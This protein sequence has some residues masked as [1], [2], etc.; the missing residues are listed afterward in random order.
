MVGVLVGLGY[1][2]IYYL[3][4]ASVALTCRKLIK[5]PDEVFR[6]TLHFILLGS[7]V[8]W[9]IGFDSWEKSAIGCIIFEIIVFPILMLFERLKNYSKVVTERKKGELKSSLLIVFT[10]FAL[11]ICL[12]WGLL[13]DKYLV[14]AS[15]YT[16]GFGDAFA[17]LIG[18]KYGKHKI[19]KKKSLEGS[20]AMFIVSLACAFIILTIR[21]ITPWY[22]IIV[23]SLLVS[24]V[25]TIVEL[26][27]PNGLDTI[28][29]PLSAMIVMLSM[30]YIFG[31]LM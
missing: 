29:C 14:F 24:F 20:I 12:C 1:V 3:I 10:T 15:I 30:L 26:Y 27:T 22:G 6:K 4:C 2:C 28:T 25:V 17:A 9:V 11:I 19:Y 8:F 5:I 18:K 16:W 7:L 31:G 23:T 13:G 21:G